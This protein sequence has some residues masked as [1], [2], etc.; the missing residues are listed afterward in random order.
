MTKYIKLNT[1]AFIHPNNN[2]N[3]NDNDI[4][5]LTSIATEVSP[6]IFV[7]NKDVTILQNQSLFIKSGQ[8]VTTFNNFTNNGTFNNQGTF[9]TAKIF[10]NNDGAKFDNTRGYTLNY[11]GGTLNF[12]D[13]K[14]VDNRENGKIINLQ[15]IYDDKGG[16]IGNQVITIE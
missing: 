4:I 8:I 7:M 2:N 6:G 16:I 10:T 12:T 15:S 3:N 14:K 1:I 9:C 11:L 13:P 5:E